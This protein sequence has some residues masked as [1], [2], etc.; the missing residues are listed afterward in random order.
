MILQL[1]HRG[2]DAPADEI[3]YQ[4]QADKAGSNNNHLANSPVEFLL[5]AV[6]VLQISQGED[7]RQVDAGKRRADWRRPGS[8][9]QLVVAFLVFLPR[10]KIADPDLLGCAID[11]LDGG[12]HADIQLEASPEPLRLHDKQFFSIGNLGAD[13]IGQAAVGEGHIRP[14]FEQNNV[15]IL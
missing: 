3:L 14:A 9:D 4:L 11:G 13:V 1:D 6:H 5:D 12:T 7:T 2:G 10:G 8:K 15:C